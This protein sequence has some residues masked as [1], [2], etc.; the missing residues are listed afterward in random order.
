[1]IENVLSHIHDQKIKPLKKAL[2]SAIVKASKK[3]CWYNPWER[4]GNQ[5]DWGILSEKCE[6]FIKEAEVKDILPMVEFLLEKA[7][8]QIQHSDDEG[9]C[10]GQARYW[11][12]RLIKA[13]TKKNSDHIT[14]I[15]WAI[16]VITKDKYFLTDAKT[17]VLDKN[18]FPS[19]ETWNEI[20]NHYKGLNL[21]IHLLALQKAGRENE[22]EKILKKSAKQK[23]DYAYLVE[24]ALSRGD[25]EEALNICERGIAQLKGAELKIEELNI[26]AARIEASHGQYDRA[27]N[28]RKK[29]LME[30]P[31][32]ENYTSLLELA[33]VQNISEQIR[34]EALE[35]L[36]VA[37]EW[38]ILMDIALQEYR[39]LDAVKYYWHIHKESSSVYYGS[40]PFK[41]DFDLAERLSGIYP[42]E[43]AKILRRVVYESLTAYQPMY[44]YVEQ[45]LTSLKSEFLVSGKFEEWKELVQTLRAD[46]PRKRNLKEILDRLS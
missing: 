41:Q 39:L 19:Q 25:C 37:Q 46:H 15:D 16:K 43:A 17:I 12:Q 21:R 44:E 13:A 4:R 11:A 24:D 32:L 26:L 3:D 20:A 28:L 10:E 9:D 8:R 40:N 2:E 30:H 33:T 35:K 5:A 7:T 23:K 34:I 22:R 27:L 45:A 6:A 18:K 36:E 29:F 1:M 14:L 42:I 31:S 38:Y